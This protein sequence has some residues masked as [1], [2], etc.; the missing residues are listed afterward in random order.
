[1]MLV[2]PLGLPDHHAEQT[3]EILHQST[4]SCAPLSPVI[5]SSIYRNAVTFQ[6]PGSAG[7]RRTLGTATNTRNTPAGIDNT[8]AIVEPRWGTD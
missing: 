5:V 6:S 3:A 7:P 8:P 2:N 1:M 4:L